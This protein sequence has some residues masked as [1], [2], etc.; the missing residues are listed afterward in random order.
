MLL[1][2]LTGCSVSD[3]DKTERYKGEKLRIG[4]IGDI[5]VIRETQVMF[6]EIDFD[7]L[8]EDD[9]DS[10]YDAIFITKENLPEAS[11]AEFAP[12]YKKSK[13]P[14][15]FVNSE[16]SHVI[17]IKENLS[18]ED[19]LDVKD[20]TYITGIFYAKDKFWGYGLYN[21][22]E[23]QTNIKGVYSRVFEDISEIKNNKLP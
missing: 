16:K 19:E 6:E 13:I 3:I 21:N 15:Y 23:S 5:P 10:K 18:Y 14:F 12:I 20:G 17:F 2:F 22:I 8:N 7:F 9:F 1:A 11:N 4:I